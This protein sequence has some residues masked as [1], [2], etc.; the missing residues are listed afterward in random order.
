MNKLKD[1]EPKPMSV[2]HLGDRVQS[3]LTYYL[4]TE[5]GLVVILGC[6]HRG[7]IKVFSQVG[8]GTTVEVLLPAS[9][10]RPEPAAACEI[11]PVP[12]GPF[13]GGIP[14]LAGKDPESEAAGAS[15]TSFPVGSV[16]MV[17]QCGNI[18]RHSAGDPAP[19]VTAISPADP[20]L[21]GEVQQ[22]DRGLHVGRFAR[23]VTCAWLAGACPPGSLEV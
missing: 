23:A 22:T 16:Y 9:N 21:W 10:R 5:V 12:D 2:Q 8:R 3:L 13:P 4:K 19:G 15:D 6:A 18:K 14:L 11:R 7:A 17:D 20:N 1:G